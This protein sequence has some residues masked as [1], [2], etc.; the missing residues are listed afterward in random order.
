[1]INEISKKNLQNTLAEM[2]TS[3]LCH[4]S[5]SKSHEQGT[6]QLKV[7][8]N[9]MCT[10]ACITRT[11]CQEAQP[12]L[13]LVMICTTSHVIK[14]HPLTQQKGEKRKQKEKM[15]KTYKKGKRYII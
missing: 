5:S 7:L 12:S 10:K 15:T 14:S 11:M 2:V 9:G 4:K 6:S 8:N 13:Q 1:M 3:M